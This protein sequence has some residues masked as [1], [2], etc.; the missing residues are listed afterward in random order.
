MIVQTLVHKIICK[1]A[2]PGQIH[3]LLQEDMKEIG[4][5]YVVKPCLDILHQTIQCQL[6]VRQVLFNLFTNQHFVMNVQVVNI[7]AAQRKV[8]KLLVNFATLANILHQAVQRVPI[9]LPVNFHLIRGL[10]CVQTVTLASIH[11]EGRLIVHRV[12]LANILQIQAVQRVPIVLPVN[13]H[14]I[15]GL[16]CVQTVT[17]ASIHYWAGLMFVQ[18][19][20][21]ENFNR[22]MVKHLVMY[23]QRENILTQ[24]LSIAPFAVL[25]S[26]HCKTPVLVMIVMLENI[27]R[28]KKQHLVMYVQRENILTQEHLFVLFAVL[29]SIHHRTGLLFV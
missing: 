11:Q 22:L 19:V 15:R 18:S 28:P 2:V 6:R 1:M 29:V 12:K 25:V 9:V 13:F 14:L 8:M 23:V 4:V 20:M 21:Q 26:I 27:N 24:E 16:L 10:L 5:A 17:L 7:Q 3:I